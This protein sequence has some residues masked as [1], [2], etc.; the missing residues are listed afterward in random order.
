MSDTTLNHRQE[1]AL[2]QI[3]AALKT[4]EARLK[5]DDA[6]ENLPSDLGRNQILGTKATCEFMGFSVAELRRQRRSSKFP[7]PVMIG[8][9][10]QGWRVGT[11]ID[12]QDSRTQ[13]APVDE[14]RHD[15]RR[16]PLHVLT[17]EPSAA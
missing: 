12:L 9:K 16:D 2:A 17:R 13:K 15:P 4:L 3:L 8:K 6:I 10:K 14:P 11:L 5:P 7:P 1:D